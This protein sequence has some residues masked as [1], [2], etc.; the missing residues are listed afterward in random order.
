MAGDTIRGSRWTRKTTE[1]VAEQRKRLKSDMSPNTTERLWKGT[2]YSLRVNPQESGPGKQEPSAA[3]SPRLAVRA[4]QPHA[5]EIGL[6]WQSDSQRRREEETAGG[7]HQGP[8]NVLGKG[9]EHGE[10]SRFPSEAE[11]AKKSPDS[12]ETVLRYT[13]AAKTK[14]WPRASPAGT[15]TVSEKRRDHGFG[16]G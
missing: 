3:G 4:R 10:R 5:R 16:K 14:T 11:E 13:L 2:E 7:K 12:Y 1:Q 8:R 15:K 6:P 9:P